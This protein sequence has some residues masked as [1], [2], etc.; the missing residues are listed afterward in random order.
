M[1]SDVRRRRT[2]VGVL[3]AHLSFVTRFCWRLIAVVFVASTFS[4]PVTAQSS[5]SERQDLRALGRD[6]WFVFTSPARADHGAVLPT[7]A[8][9]GA[10]V[11]TVP[12][13]SSTYAWMVAHPRAPVMRAVAP[14]RE[15]F[16]VPLY[17][18]GSA[19][20]LIPI[21][22]ALY[23]AGRVADDAE[24]RDAGIG[25]ATSVL[26]SSAF[27]VVLQLTITR[28]RP[29]QSLDPGHVSLPWRRKWQ[30]A[31]F[32][33]GHV[34]NPAACASFVSHRFSIGAA[35]PIMYGVVGAIGLGRIAD[36]QHWPS[37][38]VAGAAMGFAIGKAVAERHHRRLEDSGVSGR[39]APTH[40]P[41]LRVSF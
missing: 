9:T 8:V 30:G 12:I 41:I 33:S 21:S 2:H 22:G 3:E 35:E 1:R 37:D 14:F 11:V 25:C 26:V 6:S 36:G 28:E 29:R 15:N 24:L 38:V 31:S 32:P 19:L 40:I 34:A 13:D 17:E 20:Y 10:T 39:I 16:G 5:T 27:R 18:L 23:T 7:L 4:A